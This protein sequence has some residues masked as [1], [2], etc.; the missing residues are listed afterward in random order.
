MYRKLIAE[1]KKLLFG[2]GFSLIDITATKII[3]LLLQFC[4]A[5]RCDKD[6]CH[7]LNKSDTSPNQL[8]INHKSTWK[9][10][11]SLGIP[12]NVQTLQLFP[13]ENVRF[14]PCVI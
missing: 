6:L 5:E 4:T 10:D 11:P 1:L 7:F 13:V 12:S 8:Y 9:W 14:K 2:A 3:F